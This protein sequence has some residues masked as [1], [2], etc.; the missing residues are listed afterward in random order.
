MV[1]K[2]IYMLGTPAKTQEKKEVGITV[3]EVA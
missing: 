3:G 1:I 2:K